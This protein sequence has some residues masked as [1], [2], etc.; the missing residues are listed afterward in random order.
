MSHYGL[1]FTLLCLVPLAIATGLTCFG[2]RRLV[3][4]TIGWLNDRSVRRRRTLSVA[5]F[6]ASVAFFTL[7]AA[8]N[9]RPFHPS[10]HDDQMHAVQARMLAAGYLWHAPHR[11]AEFFDTFHIFMRP[12]YAPIHFPGT[13]ILNVPGV[14]LGLN[15]SVIPI[16]LLSGACV[17]VYRLVGDL[18]D[19]TAGVGSALFLW[20]SGTSRML[21]TMI[22]S[23]NAMVFLGPLLL[24][25]FMWW[26]RRQ[27]VPRSLALGFAVAF[28][29]FT[30]PVDAL[31]YA[32][33]I[34]VGVLVEI[35]RHRPRRWSLI[36][37]MLLA[38][39]PMVVLQLQFNKHVTGRWL[40]PPYAAYN[41]QFHP[42]T[43]YGG[44]RRDTNAAPPRVSDLVQKQVY[45]E[46]FMLP[47]TDAFQ[48]QSLLSG[49]IFKRVP[50][51][52]TNTLPG[53]LLL[54]VIPLGLLG[55]WNLSRWVA[56]I[57]VALLLAFYTP[58]AFYLSHYPPVVMA[59]IATLAWAGLYQISR[60][61]SV[62]WA[63]THAFLVTAVTATTLMSLTPKLFGGY[64][65]SAGTFG[66][67]KFVYQKLPE[68]VEK[69]ALVFCQISA[70]NY[71]FHDEP[72]Y[73]TRAAWPDDSDI[74]LA[75]SLGPH[76][77]DLV[78]YYDTLGQNRHVYVLDRNTLRLQ[79]F[80]T[81]RSI[82]D[83][84]DSRKKAAATQPATR[85]QE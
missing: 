25:L 64:E 12:V 68:V 8:L 63:G 38:G 46:Q 69:P 42:F 77:A 16:L 29:G 74:V 76:N 50:M 83:A 10:W 5:I 22:T 52:L 43:S 67:T 65:Y 51:T 21:A 37:A 56:V 45:Y 11:L 1:S 14:W 41:D 48:S 84:E 62:W 26:R 3:D 30:R 53:P 24:V 7:S 61:V 36:P 80:G 72:V 57:P 19:G 20:A 35:Y 31:A 85:P 66:V 6:F 58:H 60:A 39:L 15:F 32:V 73:N 82:I 54:A 18:L 49:V 47:Q 44:P 78:R 40:Y 27:N 75:Q 59:G 28:A 4:Q 79:R 33:P 2:D 70:P 17:L 9:G 81:V 13:A 23:H 71:N 55:L 34:A